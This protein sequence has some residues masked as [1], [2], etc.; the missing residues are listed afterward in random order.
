MYLDHFLSPCNTEKKL[1]KKTTEAYTSD[2]KQ[3]KK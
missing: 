2:L 3:F 1:S